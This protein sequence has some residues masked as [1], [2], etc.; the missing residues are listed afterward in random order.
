MCRKITC[1]SICNHNKFN[2]F[3]VVRFNLELQFSIIMNELD[4][5]TI[6]TIF[7]SCIIYIIVSHLNLYM[8]YTHLKGVCKWNR[9]EN[10]YNWDEN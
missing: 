1:I 6:C 8:M 5:T 10:Y 3:N 9:N 2:F 4:K 7:L